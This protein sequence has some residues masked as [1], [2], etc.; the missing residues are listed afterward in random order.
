[1]DATEFDELFSSTTISAD[2]DDT[3]LELHFGV[4]DNKK[5]NI[6]LPQKWR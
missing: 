3:D 2:I 5:L 1:M 4:L 6:L